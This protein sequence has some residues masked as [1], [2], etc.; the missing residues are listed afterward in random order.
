MLQE[1][2]LEGRHLDRLAAPEDLGG[3]KVDADVAERVAVAGDAGNRAPAAQ[4]GLHAREELDHL[5]GLRQVVVGAELQAHDAIGDVPRAVSMRTGTSLPPCRSSRH[6]SKPF[7]PG[8]ATSS[9]TT[10]KSPVLA[11]ASADGPSPAVVTS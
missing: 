7:F 3:A 8:S 11:V 10:S 2:V 4:Q 5:E 1:L 9:R 6:T